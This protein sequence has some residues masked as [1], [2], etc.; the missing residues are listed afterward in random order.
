MKPSKCTRCGGSG[1][2][3]DQAKLAKAIRDKR[4]LLGWTVE[5]MAAKLGISRSFLSD[6]E[7]ERRDVSTAR[8]K[9][10]QAL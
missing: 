1:I 2:E 10:V 8:M 7:T 4:A 3:P 6:M 5:R 9:A